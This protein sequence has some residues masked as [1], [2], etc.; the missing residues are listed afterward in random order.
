M[1]SEDK[2]SVLKKWKML[3]ILKDDYGRPFGME[4]QKRIVE[5]RGQNKR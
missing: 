4:H 3:Y 5:F 2:K 1:L